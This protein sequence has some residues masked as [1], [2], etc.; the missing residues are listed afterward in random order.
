MIGV[1]MNVIMLA[2]PPTTTAP[3]QQQSSESDVVQ[4]VHA[5]VEELLR[6]SAQSAA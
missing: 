3:T 6:E 1:L 2:P 5:A 4:N